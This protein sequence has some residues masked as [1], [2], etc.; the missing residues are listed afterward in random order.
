M[1]AFLT[2]VDFTPAHNPSCGLCV[3]KL[4]RVTV[5]VLRDVAWWFG[6]VSLGHAHGEMELRFW[7]EICQTDQL[8]DGHLKLSPVGRHALDKVVLG[9]LS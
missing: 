7:I 6:L 9:E 8:S 2:L 1:S 5:L 4:L 3:D